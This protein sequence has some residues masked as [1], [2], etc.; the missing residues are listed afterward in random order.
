MRWDAERVNVNG[1][2]NLEPKFNMNALRYACELI[3]FDSVST[4]TN[5]PISDYIQDKLSGLRFRTE[6][7]E[8]DV[9]GVIK[10]NIIGCRDGASPDG[11]IAL[12][13]HT[14]VVPANDWSLRTHGPFEPFVREGRLYG[15]G[16]TDM[17]GPIACMLSAAQSVRDDELTR[18]L[19]LCC[20]ADEETDHRGIKEVTKRSAI[21]REL[22]AGGANGV[23]GEPTE[24]E[25]VHAHKGGV[26]IVVTSHG[27]AAHSSTG[28]GINANLA[29]IPFL[30]DMKSL[31]D[32][33][34]FDRKWMDDEFDPPTI[35]LNLG[36]NDH[37]EAVNVTAARSICTLCF[38]PM[39]GTPV[40]PL[41]DRIR[42]AAETHGL[43]FRIVVQNPPFR[44]ESDNEYVRQ[45]VRLLDGTKS[46]AVAFGTDAGNMTEIANLIILGPG[47]IHQAH[48]SDEWISLP[49]LDAAS[50]GYEKMI[51]HHCLEQPEVVVRP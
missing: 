31:H 39:P 22:I 19:Y 38:R 50:A 3:E 25:V 21:F 10:V 36:I 8:Y 29:M 23:V 43:D 28:Q 51:R 32:E 26:Q 48:Q 30:S 16:S 14:D 1:D 2:Q 4:K 37:N 42:G 45:S 24:M 17:K 13:G 18:P 34:Q 44:R 11:G 9:D 6:R 35:C 15:R 27:R 41:V 20:S 7:I 49:Q 5:Q 12:F 47:S 33:T 46:R 40:D